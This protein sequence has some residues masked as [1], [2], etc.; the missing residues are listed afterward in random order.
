MEE[1]ALILNSS[2][3]FGG[4]WFFEEALWRGLGFLFYLILYYFIYYI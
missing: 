4:L 1:H 3:D 2:L